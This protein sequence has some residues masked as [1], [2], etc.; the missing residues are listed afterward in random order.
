MMRHMKSALIVT[1]IQAMLLGPLF[2]YG[3]ALAGLITRSTKPGSTT[4]FATSFSL[5]NTLQVADLDTD[6]NTVYAEVN[7][8]LTQ[9]NLAADSVE[10][11]EL[12]DNSVASANIID[13]SIL[14]AD[15]NAS[16]AIVGT[17]LAV[18]AA[19]DQSAT[20]VLPGVTTFTT[21]ETIVATLPSITTRGG[22]VQ[23]TG[24]WA[25]TCVATPGVLS[26]AVTLRVKRDAATIYTMIVQCNTAI[27]GISVWTP[28]PFPSYQEVPSAAAHVYTITIQSADANM[29]ITNPGG[30][31]TRGA[32]FVTELT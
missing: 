27:S 10:A 15:V 12:A 22:T 28:I 25:Y 18:G 4:S 2:Y 17:K 19:V 23:L 24:S 21:V 7:G 11:S 8:N 9:A 13:G 30:A 1:L 20:Q 29:G 14:N 3:P 5:G 31:S 32:A 26:Q 6:I 16:A